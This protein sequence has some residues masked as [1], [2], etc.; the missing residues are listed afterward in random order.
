MRQRWHRQDHRRRRARRPGRGHVGWT[1][2]GAHRRPGP[3]AGHRARA[4]RRRQHGAAGAADGLRRGGRGV[5]WRVVGGDARHQGGLGRPH[6]PPRPR[7]GPARPGAG[8]PVVPQHHRPLREQ[9]RLHRDGAT[10]RPACVGP[11]RPGHHRHAAVAQRT[12]PARCAGTHARV[13]RQP[14]AEVAHRAVPVEAVHD[15]VEA[16]LPSGRPGVGFAIPAGHRRV[17]HPVPDHGGGVR[18]AGHRGGAAAHR[19]PVHVHRGQHA[20]GRRRPA[21][22]DTWPTSCTAGTCRW[23]RW[24]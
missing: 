23:G 10:A 5:P 1:R 12:R 6:S 17:L 13:L 3:S 24:C 9:P 22:R 2:A 15:G 4:G 7:P 8:Q 14:A 11:V 16:L 20:R 21:R 18:E 19:R